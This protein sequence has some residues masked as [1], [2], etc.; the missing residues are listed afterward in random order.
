MDYEDGL[1]YF[2]LSPFPSFDTFAKGFSIITLA[3]F[4][5]SVQLF[6]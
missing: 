1:G 4:Y 6:A 3:K 2:F 5:I